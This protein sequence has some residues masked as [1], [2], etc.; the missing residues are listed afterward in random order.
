MSVMTSHPTTEEQVDQAN[1]TD[2]VPVV[3]FHGLWLL[4]SSW[5]R[6]A[7]AFEEAGYAP[8]TP[9]WPD[10]P[11]TVEEANAHPEVFAHKTVG[12]VADQVDRGEGR[13]R[14]PRSR[15]AADH[16]RRE[17]PHG[18]VGDRQR[19]LQEA[20]AQ[21]GRHGDRRDPQ[22]RPRAHDRQRLARGR[23]QG[24]CLRSALRL[25]VQEHSRLEPVAGPQRA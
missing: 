8:L 3:F 5:D 9:G 20:E 19:V 17:G 6:W 15:T 21:R 2:L 7:A 1:A 14:E 18:P 4:P 10:D 13:Q 25:A 11:E 23:R 22:P 16:L 24:P 12:Q